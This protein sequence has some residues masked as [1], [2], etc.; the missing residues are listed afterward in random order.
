MAFKASALDSI[1]GITEKAG[2]SGQ[3]VKG[4]EN[5][6]SLRE[7]RLPVFQGFISIVI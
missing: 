1:Q 5:F 2:T 3:D 4:R 7:E 6:L